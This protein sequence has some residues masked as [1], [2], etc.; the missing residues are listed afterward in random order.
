MQHPRMQ[1]T[2]EKHKLRYKFKLVIYSYVGT[3]SRGANG[4]SV[5]D[6]KILSSSGG[7]L[8]YLGQWPVHFN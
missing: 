7:M 2:A 8:F 4:H 6:P 3:P 1:S 5:N